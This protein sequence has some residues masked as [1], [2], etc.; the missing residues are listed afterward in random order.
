MMAGETACLTIS[1]L[2]FAPN[3]ILRDELSFG[4]RSSPKV[5]EVR[6]AVGTS[7]VG[8]WPGW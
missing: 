1:E 8:C 2:N 6:V 7:Q 4:V 3:W 5:P